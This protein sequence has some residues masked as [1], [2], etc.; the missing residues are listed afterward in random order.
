M[1]KNFKILLN[2][3]IINFLFINPINSK[4]L[5]PGTGGEADVPANVLI[6]LDVSGS[7]S[8]R[9]G[10]AVAPIPNTDSTLVLAAN[11]IKQVNQVRNSLENIHPSRSELSHNQNEFS[12]MDNAKKVVYHNGRVFTYDNSTKSL[13]QYDVDRNV[14]SNVETIGKVFSHMF[15]NG[16]D[17]ILINNLAKN[18]Y[19]KAFTTPACDEI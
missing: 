15:L 10:R 8:E 12:L 6:L 19:V 17:L 14:Q 2:V 11:K 16:N 3:L 18:Y 1:K 4:T 5:P 9:S 13:F 7:M